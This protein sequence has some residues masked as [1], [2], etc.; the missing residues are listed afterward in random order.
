[1]RRRHPQKSWRWIKKKYFKTVGKRN[2]VFYGEH[3][4]KERRLFSMARTPITRHVKVRGQANPYDPEWE[5]YFEERLGAKMYEDLQGRKQLLHLWE[6]QNGL[7][8]VCDSKITRTTG[9]HNH[10]IV[11]RSKGGADTADNRVLLHPNCHRK[12]HSQRLHVEKPRP[13]KGVNEA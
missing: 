5:V 7:C 1:M 6:E 10:H 2:W 13:A 3:D 9:W 8:P 12:V 11:W 4:G